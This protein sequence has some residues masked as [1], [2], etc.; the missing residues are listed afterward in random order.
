M[1]S[2]HSYPSIYNIGHR[3]IQSIFEDDVIVEEK[4]DGSQFSF[5]IIEGVL[6][7]RSKGVELNVDAPEKMFSKAVATVKE[8]EPFLLHGCTYRAEYLQSPNHNTL[9]YER[10]PAKNLIIFD[11]AIAEET[12]M[13]YE[14]KT[15]EA[16]RL[17]LEVVSL[18]YQG[19]VQDPTMFLSF[20]EN[21]SILGGQKIE[22]VVVKNY[23]KFGADKKVLLGKYV[24]EAFK[25]VHQGAWREK[26]PSNTD[27]ITML[28]EKY[29]TPARWAKAVQHLKEAGKLDQ[30]P[31]DIGALIQ[32]VKA[33]V[34]KECEQEI[35]ED[36]F[37]YAWG[38]IERKVVAG[39]PQ[40]YKDE[41]V[42]IAFNKEGKYG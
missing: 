14:A 40:W 26:N 8:L 28:G 12:Y 37:K 34:L 41:L 42:A 13:C 33:D 30:S 16:K 10:V 7:C 15:K 32:E 5:G 25:E 24:S 17:G 6:K 20:L 18:L 19:K 35:K 3:N 11:I 39:L 31:K 22:G 38:S 9:A 36:L 29:R 1:S 2:W 21:I 23:L 27:I 4:V